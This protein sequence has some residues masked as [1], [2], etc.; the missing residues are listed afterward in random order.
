MSDNRNATASWSGYL[1]QG[2]VGIFVALKKINELIERK[3]EG[4]SIEDALKGWEIVYEN[5]EDL[6]NTLDETSLADI[7]YKYGEERFSRPIGRSIVRERNKRGKLTAKDLISIVCRVKKKRG[8]TNPA[9]KVFQALPWNG[10]KEMW[11]Q[12]GAETLDIG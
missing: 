1:H 6:I 3:N 8:K 2:K 7:F 4:V 12:P 10:P 9:T 5:A 11:D